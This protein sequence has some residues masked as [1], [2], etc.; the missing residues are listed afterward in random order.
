M[1]KIGFYF[2]TFIPKIG[3][4]LTLSS[5][6][7]NLYKT[8]GNKIVDNH[9]LWIYDHNPYVLRGVTADKFF[10]FDL[11]RKNFT[12]KFGEYCLANLHQINSASC[13][14]NIFLGGPRLYK[15]E[16]IDQESKTLCVH[17]TPSGNDFRKHMPDSVI[18]QIKDNY[19]KYKIIQ[20]GGKD[21]KKFEGAIDC[22]GLPLWES[23]R[24][25]AS[26]EIFIGIPS[27]P[28]H[29]ADCYPRVR[30]KVVIFG[31]L[32]EVSFFTPRSNKYSGGDWYSYNWEYYNL[33]EIDVGATRSYIRI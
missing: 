30:K 5:I 7:E 1:E 25:I 32:N 18:D 20:V 29:I 6:P 16:D 17:L 3:D 10:N 22:R 14:A 24:V 8:T 9:N 28:L 27:G 21:D 12:E 2:K 19:S 33:H 4:C 23:A 31:N 15:Y 11:N 13:G 26:C